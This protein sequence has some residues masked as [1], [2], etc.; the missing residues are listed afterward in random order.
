LNTYRTPM[1][2]LE[3]KLDQREVPD[4]PPSQTATL[5][6]TQHPSPASPRENDASFSH[7]SPP[8]SPCTATRAA[9]S[10]DTPSPKQSPSRNLL[11]FMQT[12]EKRL[13]EAAKHGDDHEV[14]VLLADGA[15]INTKTSLKRETPLHKAAQ[16]GNV[17]TSLLLLLNGADT[18]ALGDHASLA[19]SRFNRMLLQAGCLRPHSHITFQMPLVTLPVKVHLIAP[20]LTE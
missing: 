18:R 13:I 14:F 15:N 1:G 6:G 4:S 2:Q 16:Y 10:L 3:S 5:P 9:A 7:L 8:G 20:Y 19:L 12:A 17:S 11:S